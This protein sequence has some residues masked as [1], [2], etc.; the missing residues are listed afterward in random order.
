M[1]E[2]FWI[3]YEQVEVIASSLTC[4]IFV[5][6]LICEMVALEKASQAIPFIDGVFHRCVEINHLVCEVDNGASRELDGTFFDGGYCFLPIRAVFNGSGPPLL[7]R[8]TPINRWRVFNV[9][10]HRQ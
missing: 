6:E 7:I 9:S 3:D 2:R 5:L 10:P 8:S 4:S 1:L